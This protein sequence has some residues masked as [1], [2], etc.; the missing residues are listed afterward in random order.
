MPVALTAALVVAATIYILFG[1]T[2]AVDS[3]A[4]F[5]WQF[6]F[7]LGAFV[8][9]VGSI[10]AIIPVVRHEADTSNPYVCG[11]VASAALIPTTIAEVTTVAAYVGVIHDATGTFRWVHHLALLIGALAGLVSWALWALYYRRLATPDRQNA[12]IYGRLRESFTELDASASAPEVESLATDIDSKLAL[13]Q[14]RRQLAAIREELA[15]GEAPDRKPA[16]RWVLGTGYVNLWERLHNVEETVISLAPR[17]QLIRMALYDVQRLRESRIPYAQQLLGVI[18]AALCR[19]SPA[20][21]EYM[22]QLLATNPAGIPSL[23]APAPPQPTPAPGGTDGSSDANG[24]GGIME[25]EAREA[26]RQVRH[27]VNA[28][29]DSRWEQL[30]RHRNRLVETVVFTRITS[31]ILLGVAVLFDVP[32]QALLAAAVFYFV[33]ALTGLFGRLQSLGG[34]EEEIEDYGLSSAALVQITPFSGLAAVGGVLITGLLVVSVDQQIGRAATNTSHVQLVQIFNL[35]EN[36]FGLLVAAVFG[37]TPALL[38]SRLRDTVQQHKLDLKSTTTS[39]PS[40]PPAGA[41]TSH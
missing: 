28:F 37:L 11:L 20:S 41:P 29:R 31:Y 9:F 4:P 35:A 33:G 36:Q 25:R 12:N 39:E 5:A 10:V 34:H 1:P 22:A 24:A 21:A 38:V 13:G 17:P 27:M 3:A 16:L 7:N 32:A 6:I 15:G 8:L 14:I 26:L 23:G 40:I 19:I 18:H 2:D 30:V